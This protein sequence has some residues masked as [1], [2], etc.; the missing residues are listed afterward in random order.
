[1][2]CQKKDTCVVLEN[3]GVRI[4]TRQMLRSQNEYG[5]TR[6][7]FGTYQKHMFAGKKYRLDL[8]VGGRS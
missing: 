4:N 8:A 1:M 2:H 3:T 6:K 5:I 7:M